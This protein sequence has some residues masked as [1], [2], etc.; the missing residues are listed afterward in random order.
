MC[1]FADPRIGELSIISRS[2][3]EIYRITADELKIRNA[4]V[5]IRNKDECLELIPK[6]MP[7]I[8]RRGK[9]IPDVMGYS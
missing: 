3:F 6:N 5:A 1:F 8:G 4:V 9:K 7:L 2:T